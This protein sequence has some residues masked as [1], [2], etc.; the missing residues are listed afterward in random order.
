M[1]EGPTPRLFASVWRNGFGAAHCT[2]TSHARTK[3]SG[4]D[5][6]KILLSST[7]NQSEGAPAL[8]A[9]LGSKRQFSLE[10]L[11]LPLGAATWPR[12]Y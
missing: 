7:A 12:T 11:L 6:W 4:N 10:P 3:A 1:M 5:E 9:T 8:R 2:H